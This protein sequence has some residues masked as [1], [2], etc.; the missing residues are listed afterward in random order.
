[1][2]PGGLK[3]AGFAR[4]VPGVN[5]QNIIELQTRIAHQEHTIAEL[6]DVLTDQQAQITTLSAQVQALTDRVRALS[7]AVPA[8]D[9]GDETPPHY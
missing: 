4:T 5:D 8:S 9:S 6:N 2:E 3:I 1:M 7:E